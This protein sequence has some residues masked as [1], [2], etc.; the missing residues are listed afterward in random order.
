[1]PLELIGKYWLVFH[2]LRYLTL[3]VSSCENIY[4]IYSL[5]FHYSNNSRIV[6]H[7]CPHVYDKLQ[8]DLILFPKPIYA[9]YI[10]IYMQ[11]TIQL[12]TCYCASIY[13][14]FCCFNWG[15][16]C[17]LFFLNLT[18]CAT[19]FCRL[20]PFINY[21]SNNATLTPLL[22][23]KYIDGELKKFRIINSGQ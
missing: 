13:F 3:I 10:Y 1:M 19:L 6:K 11:P 4:F 8:R 9:S 20:W 5:L 15:N 16:I 22:K 23:D 18:L 12:Q 21:Q 2:I 17:A 7:F 14:S